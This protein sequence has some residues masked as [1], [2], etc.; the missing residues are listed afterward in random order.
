MD[1]S[2]HAL[3]KRA[4][5]ACI[6]LC[7]GKEHFNPRPRE[8][9]DLKRFCFEICRSYFNPRP[10]EE[11]DRVHLKRKATEKD[12]NPRPR[13]EGD[14]ITIIKPVIINISIHALVKR[15]TKYSS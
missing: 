7:T 13:E 4:T 8:E 6:Q 9:G 12:F 5:Q 15:A 1:I 3:V 11:G 2:I 14:G 10:R